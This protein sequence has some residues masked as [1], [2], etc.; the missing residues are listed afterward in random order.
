MKNI[1]KLLFVAFF[2]MFAACGKPGQD[3]PAGDQAAENTNQI[4]YNE[5]M[6]VHDEVMPKMGS[7]MSLKRKLKDTLAAPGLAEDQRNDFEG[8]I[9]LLDSAHKSMMDWMHGVYPP[10][11]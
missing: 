6:D 4:L 2:G 11:D 10:P 7:L 1:V 8:R 9:R 3:V 5:A